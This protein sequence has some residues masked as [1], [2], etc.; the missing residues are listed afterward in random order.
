MHLEGSCHC[1]A[2]TFTV[3]AAS[4]VP[5]NRCYCGICR[6]LAGSGGFAINIGADYASLQVKGAENLSVYRARIENADGTETRSPAERSFCSYCGTHL[7]LW[8]ARWPDLVHP[9]AATIDTDLPEPPR[10]WH[11][12]L[13]CRAP[14]AV[15]DIRDGD[16]AFAQY[17]NRS[18]ADWH[19][20]QTNS[21]DS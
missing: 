21:P 15:P 3:E 13:A 9:L 12:M 14:W 16:E 18:L 2:V 5:F 6:K 10:R 17:P 7:W 4:S 8:D 20:E 11:M 1:Q 19:A